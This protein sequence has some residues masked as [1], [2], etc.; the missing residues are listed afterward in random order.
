MRLPAK[1]S[2][3][4]HRVHYGRYVARRL[5]RAKRLTQ[6]AD[7]ETSTALI[8]QRGRE[9]ED[10]E[11]P[12]QDAIADRDAADDDLDIIAQEARHNL[13]GRSVDAAQKA[14]YTHIFPD[15]IGYYTA[16]PLDQETKR[17]GELRQRI[18]EHLP[19]TDPVRIQSIPAI[20]A[21]ITAFQS[22]AESLAAA[23]TDHAL[24]GTR[25]EAAEEAWDK[26]MDKIYGALVSELG[27]KTAESFFP[28]TK[29]AKSKPE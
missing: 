1:N 19:D 16:A 8:N 13:A 26:L 20:E 28:K 12:I 2:H 25:L 4:S 11:G 29:S 5:R 7:V 24:A 17:Y 9:W 3:Y 15:G 21:A 14:P 6:A 22:A 23:R 10:A 27:R 18:L